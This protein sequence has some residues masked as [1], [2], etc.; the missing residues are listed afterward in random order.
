M[1]LESFWEGEYCNYKRL[2]EY[3]FGF[4][5]PWS[6]VLGLSHFPWLASCLRLLVSKIGIYVRS[7]DPYR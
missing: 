3:A 4:R 2:F 6:K 1:Y 7:M 5:K